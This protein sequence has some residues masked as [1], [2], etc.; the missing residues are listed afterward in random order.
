MSL[1]R[2]KKDIAFATRIARELVERVAGEKVTYYPISKKLNK[3]NLYG[4]AVQKIFDPPIALY[5]QVDWDEQDV[6]TNMF[7]VDIVYNLQATVLDEYLESI[8]LKIYEG[9]MI[10]YDDRRFEIVKITEPRF[11]FGKESNSLGKVMLARSVRENQF[12]ASVSASSENAARTRPDND[13]KID[14]FYNNVKF[15]FSGSDR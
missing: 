1:F 6:T 14:V 2:S 11:I 13:M 9:D 12:Y 3:S 10:E 4:E 15:A 5:C 8:N 7:G